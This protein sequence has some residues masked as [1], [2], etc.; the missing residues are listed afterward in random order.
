MGCLNIFSDEYFRETKIRKHYYF[1]FYNDLGTMANKFG[2]RI[3]G[4]RSRNGDPNDRN[5]IV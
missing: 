2:W 3:G 5:R 1:K 4:V